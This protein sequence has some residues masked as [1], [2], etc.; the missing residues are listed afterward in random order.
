MRRAGKH[1]RNV[2]L[3]VAVQPETSRCF[4]GGLTEMI[5]LVRHEARQN[6]QAVERLRKG[7]SYAYTGLLGV[8]N[9]IK[10]CLSSPPTFV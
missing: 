10:K 1:C 9:E 6:E 7:E 4:G 3:Q 2:S 8:F 5:E